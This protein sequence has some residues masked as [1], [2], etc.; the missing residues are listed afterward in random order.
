VAVAARLGIGSAE[1]ASGVAALRMHV[2]HV[3]G[4]RAFPQVGRI[5]ASGVVAGMTDA[6]PRL[7]PVRQFPCYAV[8]ANLFA[9]A[10]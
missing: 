4:V 2:A 7:A 1:A 6:S 9:E 8:G 5:D 10:R 3:V